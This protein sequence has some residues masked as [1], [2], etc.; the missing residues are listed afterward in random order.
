MSSDNLTPFQ[1]TQKYLAGGPATLS[2]NWSRFPANVPRYL[3]RGASAY[4]YDTDGKEY[5]DC[6]A[7][8]GPVLL[9]HNYYH[10]RAAVERQLQLLVSS[11]LPTLLEGE[12]A[13]RLV[14]AIPGAEHIRWACN[15]KD[16]T[17][18][19]VRLARHVTGKRGVIFCGYHGGFSDYLATTDKAGGVL[20]E[21]KT[22]NLQ[23]PWREFQTLE[24]ALSLFSGDLAAIMLEVPP[25]RFGTPIEDTRRVIEAY[26]RYAQES[27]ALFILDEIVTGFRYG[28]RG[29]QGYYGVQADLVTLS[30]GMANGYPCAALT[31]PRALMRYFEGGEVFLSTTFGAWPVGLAAC[32]A[33]LD[34]L[35]G[36]HPALVHAGT[37]LCAHLADLQSHYSLPCTLRGNFGRI[38]IDWHD[39]YGFTAME[40]HT[41][42]LQTLCAHGVIAGTA[43]LPMTCWNGTVLNQV[44]TACTAAAQGIAEAVKM[45]TVSQRIS[46][47]TIS[48]VFQRYAPQGIAESS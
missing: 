20:P 35:S 43:I 32:G 18:A 15:G 28:L 25:E 45:G 27:N 10:V 13:E 11:S 22:W 14:E 44:F 5:I 42:W 48:G 24:D 40:Y 39:A 17:E 7:G 8:L 1:K 46:G 34:V 38:V 33:V 16:V 23:V 29:A 3:L 12:L 21:V 4:V 36:E 47:K 6:I 9:G 30:K 31:G 37:A 19:A 26:K 2:K 41:L